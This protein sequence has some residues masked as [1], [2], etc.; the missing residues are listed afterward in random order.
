MEPTWTA[1]GEA[2]GMAAVVSFN[3]RKT[4]ENIDIR[5]LQI[6]LHKAG[7]ITFYTSD[8]P[9]GSKYYNAVQFL[10]N[11][12]F[13]QRLYPDTLGA[14][15]GS[16]YHDINPDKTLSEEL[17]SE[18]ISL[19]GQK[20]GTEVKKNALEISRKSKT[21]GEFIRKLYENIRQQVIFD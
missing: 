6:K 13:F 9:P 15:A 21:R 8:V 14:Q 18:W 2:A 17:R 10:G 12:E 1:L 7:A 19:S 5:K 4:L 11:R 20:F 3:Q 16:S